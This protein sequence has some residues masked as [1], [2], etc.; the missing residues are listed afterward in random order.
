MSALSKLRSIDFI[1]GFLSIGSAVLLFLPLKWGGIDYEW[2]SGPVVG[3]LVG[4]VILVVLLA[5]SQIRQ[6]EKYVAFI[7][8]L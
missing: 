4:F 8:T 6:G 3:C 2:K 1:G 7:Y 5:V